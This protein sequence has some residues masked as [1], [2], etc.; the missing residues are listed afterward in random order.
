MRT[1]SIDCIYTITAAIIIVREE[2]ITCIQSYTTPK[3]SVLLCIH[4]TC[5]VH[6]L[7]PRAPPSF[8]MCCML[9][10]WLETV[11]KATLYI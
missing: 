8:S 10:S 1:L 7:V 11:D 6:S 4:C 3:S 5:T 2:N 9:D